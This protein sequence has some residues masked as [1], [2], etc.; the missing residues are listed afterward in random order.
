ML[1]GAGTCDTGQRD[2]DT[3]DVTVTRRNDFAGT[4]HRTAPAIAPLRERDSGAEFPQTSSPSPVSASG[5]G[6]FVRFLG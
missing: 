4:R 3:D 1:D 5:E 2:S 6:L